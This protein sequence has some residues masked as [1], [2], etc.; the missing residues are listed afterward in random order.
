MAKIT[1]DGTRTF[2]VGVGVGILVVA[3]L[4]LGM[5]ISS[6]HQISFWLIATISGLAV[7]LVVVFLLYV[8]R[9]KI[10]SILAR[11]LKHFSDSATDNLRQL[12][13]DVADTLT[14]TADAR[15]QAAPAI[16][17]RTTA[18]MARLASGYFWSRS[19]AWVVQLM[20]AVFLAF[21]TLAGVALVITQNDLFA[22]QNTAFD[23][24]NM[25]S[26]R[27]NL[28]AHALQL[29]TSWL[30]HPQ[31]IPYFYDGKQIDPSTPTDDK[32]RL[33]IMSEMLADMLDHAAAAGLQ[34]LTEEGWG[35]YARDMYAASPVFRQFFSQEGVR[36]WYPSVG[37]WINFD[38]TT[39]K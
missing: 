37:Q 35:N 13:R 15:R 10:E 34:R 36:D 38:S 16:A 5:L 17:E 24:Q 8:A 26:L 7:T 6:A 12:G 11:R 14:G 25:F 20:L 4:L 28:F 21:A 18:T 22:S 9:H 39:G 27:Q 19:I 32:H 2:A 3:P 29:H 33:R 30:Q 23:Q 31:L 1:P